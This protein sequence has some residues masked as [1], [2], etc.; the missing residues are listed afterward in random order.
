MKSIVRLLG[1]L[2]FIM[3][4]HFTLSAQEVP[5]MI[6]VEQFSNTRCGICANRI[7]QLRENMSGFS[8]QIQL[9][10]YFS[11]SPYPN[12][13]LHV[14]NR[15]GNNARVDYYN[16]LGSPVVHVNG[17]RVSEGSSI[18]PVSYFEERIAETTPLQIDVIY[19]DQNDQGDA[20]VMLTYRGDITE[21]P[22]K[23][24]AFVIEKEVEAGTLSN[25]RDHH[26]VFRTHLTPFEGLDLTL[27]PNETSTYDFSF[28]IVSGWDL[29]QIA[30][31][32]FV[33]NDETKEVFNAGNSDQEVSTSTSEQSPELELTLF[34]NPASHSLQIRGDLSICPDAK[35]TIYNAKGQVEN[36][37]DASAIQGADINVSHLPSGVY[38]LTISGQQ[39]DWRKSFIIAR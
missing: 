38:F 7:P 27:Q 5:K 12:C 11:A 39:C 16:V 28:D 4:S 1:C 17:D 20:S 18:V 14:A 3:A 30:I 8:E 29:E 21:G 19:N 9:I 25:Y 32:A 36:H 26:N 10:S 35:A 22:L 2:S 37:L 23:L 15:D 31:V 13:E 6:L 33:Q 34:P 24:H